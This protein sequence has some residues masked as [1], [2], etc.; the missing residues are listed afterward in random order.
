MGLHARRVGGGRGGAAVQRQEGVT[1]PHLNRNAG[2]LQPIMKA[3]TS[4]NSGQSNRTRTARANMGKASVL[5]GGRRIVA[6][7]FG[8]KVEWR[9]VMW[10][11][12]DL[13]RFRDVRGG[14]GAIH[15]E[16]VTQRA[17]E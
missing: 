1:D 10:L 15:P 11:R 2:P 9:D 3:T 16:A 17:V 12:R 7:A 5:C 6:P 13:L 4:K 8:N 14:G